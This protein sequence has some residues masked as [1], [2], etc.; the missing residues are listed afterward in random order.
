M[1]NG[2]VQQHETQYC[3]RPDNN[4]T[5][6]WSCSK[7]TTPVKWD[8]GVGNEIDLVAMPSNNAHKG[9]IAQYVYVVSSE[10][11]TT[12]VKF[13]YGHQRWSG[14][15]SFGIYPAGLSIEP[16]SVSDLIDYGITFSY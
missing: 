7:S 11:G 3:Y 4:P 8:P 14:S 15:V 10:S 13:Q 1:N 16:N 9:Y 5:A 12:N 2:K 6:P